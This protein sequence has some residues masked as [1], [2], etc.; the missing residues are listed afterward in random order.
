MEK[1]QFLRTWARLG[2]VYWGA[3]KAV[4]FGY[5]TCTVEEARPEPGA[6]M[7]IFLRLHC[8]R[9]MLAVEYADEPLRPYHCDF[10]EEVGARLGQQLADRMRRALA[11]EHA[12]QLAAA[13]PGGP[14]ADGLLEEG[15]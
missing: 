11:E 7:R 13:R 9:H 3:R 8:S 10:E 14:S 4:P 6:G 5:L 12:E 1:P 15:E 2:Q